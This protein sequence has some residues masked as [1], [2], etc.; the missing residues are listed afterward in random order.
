M[1]CVVRACSCVEKD[2]PIAAGGRLVLDKVNKYDPG[3]L[4][5]F[6][7]SEHKQS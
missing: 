5:S 7:K 4:M 6:T 1:K 3:M 2:L